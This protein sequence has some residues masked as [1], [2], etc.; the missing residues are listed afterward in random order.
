[1]FGGMG[2][3]ESTLGIFGRLPEVSAPPEPPKTPSKLNYS[4]FSRYQGNLWIQH[5]WIT[6]RINKSSIQAL[7]NSHIGD[8]EGFRPNNAK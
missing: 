7:R 2:S 8:K 3:V 1:M 4:L 5:A 6:T